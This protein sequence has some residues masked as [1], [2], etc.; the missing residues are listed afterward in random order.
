MRLRFPGRL[1]LGNRLSE[2]ETM[3]EV[4]TTRKLSA[5]VHADVKG[6]SRLMGENEAATVKTLTEYKAE[7]VRLVQLHRGRVVD[8]A[9]DGFLLAF[10]SIVDAIECSLA[11]QKVLK[12][13]NE[14]L[15]VHRKMEFRIGINVGDVIEGGDKIYGDGVN[16]AARI[17]GLADGGG[18]AIS[19]TAYD[20]LKKKVAL[21]YQYLGEKQVKNIS[22]P[23]R[24]YQIIM[25]PKSSRLEDRAGIPEPPES[26]QEQGSEIVSKPKGS[27]HLALAV[28]VVVALVIGSISLLRIYSGSKSPRKEDPSADNAA[29]KL[30]EKPSV[31]VL[32]LANA[33]GDP[34]QDYFSDGITEEIITSLAKIPNLFVIAR[35]SS[36]KFKGKAV[37]A[38]E[39]GRDLGVRYVLDGS[40][41]K[42]GNRIRIM[43]RLV[44][45]ENGLQLWGDRYD[46]EMNDIFAIQDEI[47][48]KVVVEL[49]VK[50]LQGEQ[51]R[52]W[53]ERSPPKNLEAYE[54]TLQG[55]EYVSR[56]TK[57]A[58]R[59]ARKLFSDAIELDSENARAYAGLAWVCVSDMWWGW[60]KHPDAD[61]WDAHQNAQKAISLNASLDEPHFV[62]GSLYLVQRQY[63]NAVKEGEKAVALNPSGA[64]ASAFLGIILN[65]AG[66]NEEAL[67]HVERAIR[68]NPMPPFWYLEFLASC[69]LSARRY[70]EA[71]SA[72][73]RAVKIDSESPLV[74]LTLAVTYSFL[75][76][77]IE[78]EAAAKQFMRLN[79]AFSL[80]QF[81]KRLPYKNPDD[82][83][84][85]VAALNKLGV[86]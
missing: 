77:Q 55:R 35:N 56:N 53:E 27:W 79:P 25:D 6:Y 72:L 82:V 78:A 7:M 4:T 8:T 40:V 23:V 10:A 17:E 20:Q 52:I 63:E 42:S 66:N 67:H 12:V 54:K 44:D 16:I 50:L 1:D 74:Y 60:S 32:P 30:P 80:E 13:R 19:G 64:D 14:A 21:E 76:R 84:R 83:K 61:G 24:V 45:A 69:H 28:I 2:V 48:R 29:L 58:N 38:Q 70:E 46:K 43:V 22:D 47:T 86:E 59:E 57:D 68:L 18:I 31:G 41:R 15:P 81:A 11:F 65:Y 33:S 34:S 9:G 62:M 37:T 26:G 49:R 39:V 36:F 75:D 73:K 5:I 51:A 71:L 85:I 3:T